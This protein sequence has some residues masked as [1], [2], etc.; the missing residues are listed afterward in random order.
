LLSIRTRE[1][2]VSKH[3]TNAVMLLRTRKFAK[4]VYK[5]KRIR[6]KDVDKHMKNDN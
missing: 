3:R 2:D 1:N 4:D 6:V 5:G